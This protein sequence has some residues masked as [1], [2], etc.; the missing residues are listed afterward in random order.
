[1]KK[2]LAGLLTL[3]LT[4]GAMAG[5]A[6]QAS[7]VIK[8]TDIKNKST[9]QGSKIT[10]IGIN[11]KNTI[12]SVKI[13][14]GVKIKN[15]KIENKSKMEGSKVTNVGIGQDNTIGSVDIGDNPTGKSGGYIKVRG[16]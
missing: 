10:N 11:Q 14:K 16:R 4:A 1:M 6:D 2:L 9:I 13:R 5:P 15:S 7:T 12:G 8:N 3:G